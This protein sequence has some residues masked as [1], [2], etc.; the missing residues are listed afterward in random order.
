M[1]NFWIVVHHR[2]VML[3]GLC[4]MH[5]SWASCHGCKCLTSSLRWQL[6]ILYYDGI[7]M[8]T[9]CGNSLPLGFCWG[10]Q[11][12][13]VAV[14]WGGM[15]NLE[16]LSCSSCSQCIEWC[17]GYMFPKS[18]QCHLS[19]CEAYEM[20]SPKSFSKPIVWWELLTSLLQCFWTIDTHVALHMLC[21]VLKKNIYLLHIYAKLWCIAFSFLCWWSHQKLRSI[22]SRHQIS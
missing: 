10:L 12:A 17:L 19:L 9:N 7:T 14:I 21:S 2:S 18:R 13:P 15:S 1:Q 3:L 6:C 22:F 11:E 8:R 4:S 20:A 5:S 16:W